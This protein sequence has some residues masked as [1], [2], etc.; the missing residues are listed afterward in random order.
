MSSEPKHLVVLRQLRAQIESGTWAEGERMPTEDELAKEFGVSRQTVRRAFQDLVADGL[1]DR[2]RGRGT[3]VTPSGSLYLR[4][5]GSVE[6]LLSLSV[7]TSMEIITGL[8]LV[9]DVAAAGRLRLPD[10]MVGHVDF[11]RIHSGSRF[12]WT[13]V[14][15]APATA[16]ELMARGEL[17]A[18]QMNTDTVIGL[19]ESTG[20]L[21]IDEAHQS[22]TA[23][24]ADAVAAR[25][26]GCPE[27]Q[28]LLRIDRIYYAADGT[29]LELATS[30]F[31][32]DRYSYRT[33]LR[34]AR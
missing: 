32:S 6:D 26:L 4:Q 7:D 33:V 30:R 12:C 13:Q 11:A 34:R 10:D 25:V 3:F 17:S 2:T 28:S 19:I 9:V 24:P 22:I 15:I 5:V 14:Y 1:V 8:S 31:V 16:R 27:G 18:G 29:P 23:E 20:T 21:R